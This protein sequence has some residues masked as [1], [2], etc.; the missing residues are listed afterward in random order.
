MSEVNK[1]TKSPKITVI[2]TSYN[3]SSFIKIAIES[4]LNSSFED[5]ELIISDDCSKD[6]SYSI[7]LDFASKD[8]RVKVFRNEMNIGDYPNRMLSISRSNGKWIKFV[9]CDDF[10]SKTCLEEMYSFAEKSQLHFGICAPGINDF[11]VLNTKEAFDSGY[12]NY[13]GPTGSFF[14]KEKYI[15]LGGFV[16]RITVSDWHM[17]Q[18]FAMNG[19]IM[20]FP[21]RLATWRDHIDNTLKSDSHTYG[22]IQYL[23]KS[24]Y[25]I[26]SNKF[27]PDL[28]EKRLRSFRKEV[29]NTFKMSVKFS[30]RA[31]RIKPILNFIKYNYKYLFHVK[32]LET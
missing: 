24:K 28:P 3:R 13:F 26:I 32:F 17:W 9:D 7:A 5:F 19:S 14:T 4:V 11:F 23:L 29:F 2:I 6:D 30:I 16:N 18:R 8:E 21:E 31:K 1:S 22:V 15:E 25:E 10:I 20:I 12:L 27:H